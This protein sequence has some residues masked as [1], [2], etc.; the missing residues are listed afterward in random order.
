MDGKTRFSIFSSYILPPF[1]QSNTKTSINHLKTISD[2]INT[3][4]NPSLVFGDFNMVYWADE[5]LEFRSNASLSN[6]RREANIS[7]TRQSFDHMFFS[8]E[9]E[10]TVFEEILD[11][12]GKHIGIVGSYQI[13]SDEE[14]K[15][16]GVLSIR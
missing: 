14:L 2:K 7:L 6:S 10:C 11:Q 9:L 1:R 3:S 4:P 5:I 12:N 15:T 8:K 13:K 16:V